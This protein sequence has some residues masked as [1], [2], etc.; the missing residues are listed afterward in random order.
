MR[1]AGCILLIIGLL[2]VAA[3]FL[4][5][6]AVDNSSGVSMFGGTLNLGLLQ[7]QMMVLHVGLTGFLA[8]AVL[9]GAGEIAERLGHWP[10][11]EPV[12]EA[13]APAA[14]SVTPGVTPSE[15]WTAAD[16][17]AVKVVLGVIGL[18]LLGLLYIWF[19][20]HPQPTAVSAASDAVAD[21]LAAEADQLSNE[22]SALV[23]KTR[24]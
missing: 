7:N 15:E 14:T 4:M 2:C 17:L 8:G 19:S 21:N 10:G 13:P 24:P 16:N 20:N 22:A 9:I 6:T 1:V 12:V 5:P 18:V 11:S 3:S 23:N